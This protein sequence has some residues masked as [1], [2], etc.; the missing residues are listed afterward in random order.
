MSEVST[1]RRN[2]MR[3][4]AIVP[5]VIAAPAV[6]T[7]M[8]SVARP[9]ATP[10]RAITDAISDYHKAA[11]QENAWHDRAYAPAWKACKAEV[12][13]IPHLTTETRHE[14]G[15][16]LVQWSTD[17]QSNLVEARHCREVI[18]EGH[19]LAKSYLALLEEFEEKL[20]WRA[21]Q[22]R[23]IHQRHSMDALDRE[24]DRLTDIS[25]RAMRTV[26]HF[27]VTTVADLIAKVEFIQE[28]EGQ[29]DND[30]VL[31]DLRRIAGKALS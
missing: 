31:T 11:N 26:E 29:V 18:N 22:E 14:C 10:S 4:L 27:P 9:D 8:T 6:A 5:A 17:C 25:C 24:Q 13:K 23:R 30:E 21:S 15:G 1:S 12:A 7:A 16:K 19:R 2:V 20:A 28:T 3:A